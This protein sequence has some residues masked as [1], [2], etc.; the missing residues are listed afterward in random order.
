MTF[1][2]K[3]RKKKRLKNLLLYTFLII[4]SVKLFMVIDQPKPFARNIHLKSIELHS[5]IDL[6]HS[7]RIQSVCS[8]SYRLRTLSIFTCT[9]FSSRFVLQ[10]WRWKSFKEK[11]SFEAKTKQLFKK[12]SEINSQDYEEKNINF[13]SNLHWHGE[14]SIKMKIENRERSK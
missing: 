13:G 6:S 14:E 4:T 2:S 3:G 12:D 11:A 1:I 8:G 9:N 7:I 10:Y 5:S